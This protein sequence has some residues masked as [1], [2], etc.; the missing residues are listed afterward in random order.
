MSLTARCIGSYPT[1]VKQ[2]PRKG[3]RIKMFIFEVNG[4]EKELQQYV[5]IQ[6][7]RVPDA[8]WRDEE[9]KVFFWSSSPSG[10]N[11][12]LGITTNG[13]IFE[14][15]TDLDLKA[16]SSAR[17]DYTY[18]SVKAGLSGT[19]AVRQPIVKEEPKETPVETPVDSGLED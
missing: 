15:T 2:G 11:I 3:Q 1:T 7:E 19:G 13:N 10:M 12:S 6:S 16:A 18:E 4:T 8:K 9:G 17:Y 5:E 14:D